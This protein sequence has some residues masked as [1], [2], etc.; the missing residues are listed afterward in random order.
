M[1][2]GASLRSRLA[3]QGSPGLQRGSGEASL[4]HE[5]GGEGEASLVL[6]SITCLVSG[7]LCRDPLVMVRA[8]AGR[9]QWGETGALMGLVNLT[10]P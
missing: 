10:C 6:H 1:P 4:P 3:P 5:E 9:G 8:A 2:A 7:R